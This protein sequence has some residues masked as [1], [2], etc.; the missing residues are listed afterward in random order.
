MASTP[1]IT[2]T[3]IDSSSRVPEAARYAGLALA[4][5]ALE[6]LLAR[7]LAAPE[8]SRFVL[9]FA[10]VL[11]VALV[12]RF[13]LATALL[14]LG[15]TDFVFH[16]TFFAYEVGALSVRPHE[17][18]LA[19]LF[20]LAVLRPRRS[21][22]GG[23]AGIALA[24]F[25]ALI[26]A[27]G[28]LA[29]ADG[30]APLTDVFNW[31]RSF[32]PLTLFYVIVRLFPAPA[33][34]RALLTGAAVIAAAAGVVAVLVALGWSVGDELKG[35]GTQIVR[36]EEGLPG[37]LRV[38]LAG[39]SLAYGLF[40]Y[41]AVR[42]AGAAA[43]RR[44]GW[45]LMLTAVGGAIAVSFNRN[46]WI[47]L[48]VGLMLML[49]LGGPWVRSRLVA[50]IAIGAAGLALLASVG[51]TTDTEVLEPVVK[52]GATLF[53]PRGVSQES[54]LTEREQETGPAW[55]AAKR[56]PLLGVG[57]GVSFGVYNLQFVGP[58]SIKLEP[59]LFLHNQYLYL[60]LIGGVPGLF[61]FLAFLGVPL[62]RAVTRLPRDPAI[63]ACGV[64]IAMIMV[65]SVV[66]IY[67]S[68]EDMTAVLG[69][70][71]GIVV[72]D[73]EGPALDGERSGLER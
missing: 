52:R 62:A 69:L 73:S 12:F 59:Q 9:L 49:V 16:S 30:N 37:L 25:L 68:V 32:A 46:M 63:T 24:I 19:A 38:R 66:A 6:V 13:P 34:R 72:A 60:L 70:L 7:G 45:V 26:A 17:L 18:A 64:G 8:I 43:G 31:G 20:A 1:T 23:P 5:L 48:V 42:A 65:S 40:W 2:A 54:S 27:S 57:P 53:D 3:R 11:V 51:S 22:W 10:G 44:I 67:F 58:H 21:T 28:A 41:V 55:E 39:L 33:Q 50:A 15:F 29:V 56:N 71:T 14:F 36:E 4:V 35:E 61:A 47:G